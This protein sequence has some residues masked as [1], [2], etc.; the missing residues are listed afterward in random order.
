M[1]RMPLYLRS[2]GSRMAKDLE[3]KAPSATSAPKTKRLLF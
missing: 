3:L 1:A 2:Q